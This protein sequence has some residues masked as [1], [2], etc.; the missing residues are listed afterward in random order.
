MLRHQLSLHPLCRHRCRCTRRA[1]PAMPAMLCRSGY[2]GAVL[3][4]SPAE[5]ARP[6]RIFVMSFLPPTSPKGSVP[7]VW[8]SKKYQVRHRLA[9]P[10]GRD[11]WQ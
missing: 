2:L 1:I 7:V 11:T 6:G 4:F 3:Q 10:P 5:K 9:A 8:P